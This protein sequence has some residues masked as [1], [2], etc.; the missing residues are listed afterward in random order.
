MSL[1]HSL[2]PNSSSLVFSISHCVN[3]SCSL[4]HPS[5]TLPLLHYLIYSFLL[6]LLS[7]YFRLLF[8]SLI[9]SIL[10]LLSLLSYLL[11]P[12]SKSL[13]ASSKIK[14]FTP[15]HFK[16]KPG[17]SCKWAIIRPSDAFETECCNRKIIRKCWQQ[18][19]M[20]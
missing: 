3:S 17:V 5:S 15:E 20:R 19:V 18:E 1:S 6:L 10:L 13:S 14:T 4:P 9:G 8:F 2:I 16:E 11:N 7:L 12:I